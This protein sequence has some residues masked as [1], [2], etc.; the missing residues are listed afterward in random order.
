VYA[1]RSTST[2]RILNRHV[3]RRRLAQQP[4]SNKNLQGEL[5][6]S[7]AENPDCQKLRLDYEGA[8]PSTRSAFES[9]LLLLHG[10]GIEFGW[11]GSN[12]HVR[13][14]DNDSFCCGNE[15]N[16]SFCGG[17]GKR[18]WRVDGKETRIEPDET[19]SAVASC[20][21]ILDT[22]ITTSG[23]T[24]PATSL[25][26]ATASSR[27]IHSTHQD[28]VGAIARVVGGAVIAL[29]SLAGLHHWIMRR[30]NHRNAASESTEVVEAP[31]IDQAHGLPM[32]FADDA[33][34]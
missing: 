4:Q 5:Y 34:S 11:T 30:D 27:K 14:R 18:V 20:C 31:N 1:A 8:E 16:G 19:L 25:V 22:S 26:S 6:R 10:H 9:R 17:S 2:P 13:Q 24:T 15:S 12:V 7:D 33:W 3:S 21:V 32:N 28:K 29:L 23:S